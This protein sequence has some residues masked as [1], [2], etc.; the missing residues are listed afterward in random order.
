MGH[1]GEQAYSLGWHLTFLNM[2]AGEYSFSISGRRL[3]TLSLVR[4]GSDVMILCCSAS[5]SA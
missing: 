1:Y 3:Y 4:K 2:A 5:T